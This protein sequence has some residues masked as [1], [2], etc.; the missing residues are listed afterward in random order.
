M[1][2]QQFRTEATE[3]VKQVIN[4]ISA[5]E[6]DKLLSVT[7]LHSSWCDGESQEE[8]LAAFVEWLEGQLEMWAE[9]YEKEFVIDAFE[10]EQLDIMHFEGNRGFA[11]YEPQSFGEPLDFW[12]EIEFAIDEQDKI[13]SEINVNI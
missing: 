11:N 6:Y 1:T 8:G 10:E 2:E 7:T 13:T 9:D 12:F 5:H 4:Y 3:N